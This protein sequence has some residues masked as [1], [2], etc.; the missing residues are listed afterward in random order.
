MKNTLCKN[1]KK[2]DLP[3]Y[4]MSVY[5]EDTDS[6]GIVYHSNYLKYLSRA[7]EEFLGKK[8]LD[9]FFSQGKY[10]VVRNIMI[11]YLSSSKRGDFLEINTILEFNNS[12]RVFCYHEIS[13][14]KLIL[15]KAKVSL[16][17]L[18]SLGKPVRIKPED[19]AFFYSF[20]E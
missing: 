12:P 13:R 1:S 17:L 10:F 7:R 8:C 19:D 18:N 11:D 6:T 16:V 20:L 9:A 5:Y 3:V 4:K 14:D 15:L 2:F